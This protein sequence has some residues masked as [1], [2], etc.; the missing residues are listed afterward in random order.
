[1]T[2]PI[3]TPTMKTLI[4][5]TGPW[6]YFLRSQ[7][8]FQEHLLREKFQTQSIVGLTPEERQQ[9]AVNMILSQIVELGELLGHLNFKM[10]M[11]PRP[12]D[13][14]KVKEEWIDAFKYLLNIA[15]YLEI[16][17]EEIFKK[18]KE[19]TSMVWERFSQELATASPPVER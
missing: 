15:L 13:R 3:N 8:A 19:K 5:V 7:L 11:F 6:G 17:P 10:H 14:E 9:F 18:F 1:M 2:T 16:T 12:M 4:S